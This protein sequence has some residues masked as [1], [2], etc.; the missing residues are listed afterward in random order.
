MA[1]KSKEEIAKQQGEL[2]INYVE[3]NITDIDQLAKIV[4]AT[5]KTIYKWIKELNLDKLKR[6]FLLTYEEQLAH[7]LNELVE[8]NKAIKNKPEGERYADFKEAQI[9]RSLT[10][11][12]EALKTKD[13]Q[14]PEMIS[15]LTKFLNF[16]RRNN[17]KQAQEISH[18]V[19]DFI[20]HEL[21]K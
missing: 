17:L 5:K 18:L 1:R 15:A 14:L 12:I 11:D 2:Q 3:R 9:R 8:I 7:L 10:K 6:N 19:D 20:K 16:I 13:A 4:G 21:R